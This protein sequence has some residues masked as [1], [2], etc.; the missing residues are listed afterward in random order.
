MTGPCHRA[1]G[2]DPGSIPGAEAH[3]FILNESFFGAFWERGLSE[4]V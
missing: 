3:F 4:N 2:P 1:Y